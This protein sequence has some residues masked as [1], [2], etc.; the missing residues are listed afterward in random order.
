[1]TGLRSRTGVLAVGLIALMVLPPTSVATQEQF[2]F[3][4]SA[5]DAEGRPVTDLKRDEIVM[6][7]NGIANEIV[8]I[9]AFHMSVKLTIA[10]DNGL[11]SRTLWLTIGPGSRDSP[12][13]CRPG[14]RWR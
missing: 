6:L 4:I 11:L 8:K 10:V 9:E 5:R 13:R 3:V 2:Q 14:S 12:R 7:E 1:M